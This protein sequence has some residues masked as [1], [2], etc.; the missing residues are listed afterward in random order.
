MDDLRKMLFGAGDQDLW[1][2]AIAAV[3]PLPESTDGE[4][5][6]WTAALA[7][8]LAERPVLRE[9]SLDVDIA[10]QR[11][12]RAASERLAAVDL[13]LTAASAA[14]RSSASFSFEHA[15]RATAAA[16]N[17]RIPSLIETSDK[18][19]QR[20]CAVNHIGMQRFRLATWRNFELCTVQRT[21]RRVLQDREAMHV[22]QT[23]PT[24]RR[25]SRGCLARGLRQE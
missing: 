3:T 19:T 12:A 23:R 16:I 9:R 25:H 13:E 18:Q 1:D 24:V 21:V 10:R 11:A 14:R 5:P 22:S 17:A 4:V 2:V 8:A 15:P 6:H 7:V 20:D